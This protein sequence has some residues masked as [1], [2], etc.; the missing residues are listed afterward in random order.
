MNG[1]QSR[2]LPN[3]IALEISSPLVPRVLTELQLAFNDLR[4]RLDDRPNLPDADTE[5]HAREGLEILRAL[6]EAIDN[7]RE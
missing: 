3:G 1:I 7:A 5:A 2:K 6:G 4:E